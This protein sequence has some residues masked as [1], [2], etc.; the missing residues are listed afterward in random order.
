MTLTQE[1]LTAI[2]NSPET[3]EWQVSKDYDWINYVRNS[4]CANIGTAINYNWRIKKKPYEARHEIWVS[5]TPLVARENKLDQ[6]FASLSEL[7]LGYTNN[8]S[9]VKSDSCT[10]KVEIIIRE[11]IE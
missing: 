2:K 8:W 4:P 1:I 10:K 7:L 6:H 3:V 11:I 9:E 5:A